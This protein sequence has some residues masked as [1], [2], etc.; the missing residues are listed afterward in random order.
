MTA[1]MIQLFPIAIYKHNIETEITPIELKAILAK[2]HQLKTKKTESDSG[3]SQT[4]GDLHEYDEFL[5]LILIIKTAIN[6]Y[7]KHYSYEYN[8]IKI[9]QMWANVYTKHQKIHIHRHPNSFLSG[10]I[11]LQIDDKMHEN[12]ILTFYDPLN[13]LKSITL[14]K[15]THPNSWNSNTHS[16][17]FKNFDLL[18]FPGWLKHATEPNMS[19]NDRITISFNTTLIGGIGDKNELTYQENY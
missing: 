18:I 19:T 2:I 3:P 16:I 12:G 7:C 17:R 15:I 9:Q 10:I 13:A 6:E 4:R 5:P 11:T 14:P 8:D 1:N